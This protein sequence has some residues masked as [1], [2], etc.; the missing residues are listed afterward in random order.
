MKNITVIISAILLSNTIV[1]QQPCNGL[2][3]SWIRGGNSVTQSPGNVIGTCNNFDF[4]LKANDTARVVLAANGR[5]FFG[6][7]RIVSSHVHAN[8]FMQVDGK[9][10]CKELVI[11]DPHKWSDF[12]FSP[13]YVLRP[14]REVE[15][16][17]KKFKRLPDIPSETEVM[18]NGINAAEM[19]AL[20][21][22]KIEELTLYIVEIHKRHE[23]LRE[24][25]LKLKTECK[26]KR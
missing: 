2:T 12:V 22:Q 16:F 17:Y 20:L 13:G 3:Q 24:E 9:L 11:V 25:Y 8:S 26:G 10:A 7:G 6:N 14:L 18:K 15:L 19:D 1:A 5:I 23:E 21:L 4:I